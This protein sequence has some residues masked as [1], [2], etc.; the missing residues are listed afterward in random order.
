MESHPST[1]PRFPSTIAQDAR[2]SAQDASTV[3]CVL[4][5][6]NFAKGGDGDALDDDELGRGGGLGHCS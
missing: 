4:I 3:S 6:S 1:A 5:L 2:G